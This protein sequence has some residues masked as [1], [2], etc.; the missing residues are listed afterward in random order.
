[1][2]QIL[3]KLLN[4]DLY[5][6]LDLIPGATAMQTACA[7]RLFTRIMNKLDPALTRKIQEWLNTPAP[8]RDIMAGAT[9]YL[10]L[11]RNR[12]LYNS[13]ISKP[14]KYMPKLEYELRKFLRIR[15]DKMAVADIV[16]LESE[17]MPKAAE[18][19]EQL[20]H[21]STDDELPEATVARGRRFDH[22]SL[23]DGIKELWDSNAERHRR[24]VL[25]FNELKGMSE[26][27]PCDRYEKLRILEELD[28][29]YRSNLASYDAYVLA[30]VSES[31]SME[32]ASVPASALTVEDVANDVPAEG[33]D[34]DAAADEATESAPAVD[35]ARKIGAARKT[36][37]A[38]K[39]TLVALNPADEKAAV[40]RSKI[41]DAVD[42]VRALG[43]G[44]SPVQE[45][46]LS[47]L[48]IVMN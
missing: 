21:I 41:Q 47:Q 5:C 39:K 8:E 11:S 32:P 10:Q 33:A 46:E 34:T 45:E 40:L 23:P 18:T 13:V 43:G 22:D 17:V 7:L 44:F 38:T 9:L 3:L 37:S 2:P 26:M 36:V 31:V 25:L 29:T 48:G 27:A 42:T 28:R 14:Q 15:L 6:F 12:A 24:I 35:I 4:L 20:H 1:M 30:P 19:V 16:R